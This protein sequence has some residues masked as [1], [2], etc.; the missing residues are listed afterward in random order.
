MS[1]NHFG[2]AYLEWVGWQPAKTR[3]VHYTMLPTGYPMFNI[4]GEGAPADIDFI[5]ACFSYMVGQLNAKTDT[6]GT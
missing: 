2:D 3:E 6:T 5:N 4:H 1:G